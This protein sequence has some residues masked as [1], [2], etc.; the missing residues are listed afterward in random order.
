MVIFTSK[1]LAISSVLALAGLTAIPAAASDTSTATKYNSFFPNFESSKSRDEVREEY[2]KAMKDGSLAMKNMRL[3]IAVDADAPGIVNIASTKTRDQVREGALQAMEAMKAGGLLPKPG[4]TEVDS[5][6]PA[7]A[8]ATPSNVQRQDVFAE[9]IEWMR[10]GS[11]D[12]GM[13]D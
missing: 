7:L 4:D 6:S 10:I 2:F 5:E 3:G 11:G 13:G 1:I 9:T 8:K 12:I